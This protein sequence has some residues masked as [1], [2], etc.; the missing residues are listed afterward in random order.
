MSPGCS[1]R[2]LMEDALVADLEVQQL[3]NAEGDCSDTGSQR[4]SLHKFGGPMK[5]GTAGFRLE[6]HRLHQV[7]ITIS[8]YETAANEETITSR[9]CPTS[10][11][12]RFEIGFQIIETGQDDPL[13]RIDRTR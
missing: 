13:A 11:A 2:R 9:F 10:S 4:K 12:N 3:V 5:N 6:S 8:V 1:W 7:L